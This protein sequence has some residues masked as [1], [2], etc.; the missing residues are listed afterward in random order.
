[1]PASALTASASAPK[2]GP[3]PYGSARPWRQEKGR[4]SGPGAH[5]GGQAVGQLGQQP[6]LADA[7]RAD[8]GDQLGAAAGAGGGGEQHVQLAVPGDQ[9]REPPAGGGGAGPRGQR[10]PG[11]KRVA[12]ARL[13]RAE[14]A[15]GDRPLGGPPGRLRHQHGPVRDQLLQPGGGAHGV[16]DDPL[17]AGPGPGGPHQRLPGGHGRLH[18]DRRPS[19]PR[20][21]QGVA[22]G[23]GGPHRPLGVVVAGPGDAEHGHGAPADG[24]LDH[25]AVGL[26][27]GPHQGQSAR[28]QPSGVLRV[29]LGEAFAGFV[30][31]DQQDGD[32]LALGAALSIRLRSGTGHG[33]SFSVGR[34]DCSSLSPNVPAG[35]GELGAA[36]RACAPAPAR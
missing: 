21:R 16:A 26:D 9:G 14:G 13:A 29:H 35:P 24:L 12:G 8:H 28:E 4:G 32:E 27:L 3:S 36:P 11:R 10:R 6:A 18:P 30:D 23:Q 7:G 33:R 19:G 31:V 25:A 20:R 15:V 1:M 2:V 17:A 34:A 5:A 22:D